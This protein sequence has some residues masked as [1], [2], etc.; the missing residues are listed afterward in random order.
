MHSDMNMVTFDENFTILKLMFALLVISCHLN[1]VEFSSYING[2]YKLFGNASDH[3]MY[4]MY[5]NMAQL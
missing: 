1:F 3:N 4:F 5:V 2:I